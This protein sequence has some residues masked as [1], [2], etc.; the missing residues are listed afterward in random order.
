[1]ISKFLLC[2]L[3]CLST[4]Q[5]IKARDFEDAFDQ[6]QDRKYQR[7]ES[8]KKDLARSD[9][10]SIRDNRSIYDKPH[11]KKYK[12]S[13]NHLRDSIQDQINEY[14][15]RPFVRSQNS[16]EVVSPPAFHLISQASATSSS[17]SHIA[18]EIDYRKLLSYN[19]KNINEDNQTLKAFIQTIFSQLNEPDMPNSWIVYNFSELSALL[20]G[21][22]YEKWSNQTFQYLTLVKPSIK[23]DGSQI[24][25]VCPLIIHK[26]GTTHH[27]FLELYKKES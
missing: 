7:E 15:F 1:M 26:N 20:Q 14:N 27:F 9:T 11:H 21:V 13:K 24:Q 4:F 19:S 17:A 8:K 25:A 16:I 12:K 18:L 10:L 23:P 5:Q 3:L 22:N 6:K 2:S